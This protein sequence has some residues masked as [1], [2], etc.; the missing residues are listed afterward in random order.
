LLGAQNLPEDPVLKARSQRAKAQGINEADLP[1]VPRSI[2]EPPPL[3]PPETHHKDTRA[4]RIELRARHASRRTG[5]GGRHRASAEGAPAPRVAKRG[6]HHAP[7]EG[8]HAPRAAK[9]GKHPGAVAKVGPNPR[10]KRK[11]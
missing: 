5:K 4:G 11:A 6:K 1:P 8:T 7:A 2:T 9:A 3:P 10:K